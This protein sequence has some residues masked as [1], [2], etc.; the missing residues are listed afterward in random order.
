[1]PFTD[2]IPLVL[3]SAEYIVIVILIFGFFCLIY[4]YVLIKN[5]LLITDLFDPEGPL[6]FWPWVLGYQN[7]DPTIS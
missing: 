4:I 3:I 7:C 6:S 2:F 5:L 1:M